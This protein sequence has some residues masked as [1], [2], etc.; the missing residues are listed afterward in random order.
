MS[1]HLY[2]D[3]EGKEGKLEFINLLIFNDIASLMT[4]FN[5]PN[6]DIGELCSIFISVFVS[7]TNLGENTFA[8]KL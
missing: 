6:E 4:K 1:N 8:V 7:I 5:P 3:C 2:R